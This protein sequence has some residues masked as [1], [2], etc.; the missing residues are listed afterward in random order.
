[1]VCISVRNVPSS[2]LFN[3]KTSE[4]V[5]MFPKKHLFPRN[6]QE[7]ELVLQLVIAV[8]LHFHGSSLIQRAQ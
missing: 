6:T 3:F 1:M 2:S 5:E 7:T 4:V 8:S